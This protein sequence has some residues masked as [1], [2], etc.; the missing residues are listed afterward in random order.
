MFR[1]SLLSLVLSIVLFCNM[2]IAQ[3]VSII[4]KQAESTT[5]SK[6]KANLYLQIV[7]TLTWREKNQDKSIEYANKVIDLCKEECETTRWEAYAYL[8]QIGLGSNDFSI[9]EQQ[10]LP[11]LD[12]NDLPSDKSKALLKEVAGIYFLINGKATDATVA[13]EE[14]RDILKQTNPSSK[15][16][17]N[18]YYYLA[19]SYNANAVNQ[20]SIKAMEQSVEQSRFIKDSLKLIESLSGLS[21]L[22]STDG[23]HL[24]GISF[25]L[26][27]LDISNSIDTDVLGKYALYDVLFDLYIRNGDYQKAKDGLADIIPEFKALDIGRSAKES[28]LWSFNMSMA[29]VQG[30]LGEPE[31]GLVYVDSA[32]VYINPAN[33]FS[34]RITDLRQAGLTLKSGNYDLASIRLEQ[35]LLAMKSYGNIDAFNA[36]LAGQ[37]A[38]L[39]TQSNLKP[40]EGILK[41]LQIIADRVIDKNRGQFNTDVSDAEM[42]S[43]ILDS[44]YQK[45]NAVS[46]HLYNYKMINDTINSREKM[47]V[48]NELLVKY[49]TNE[50]EKE[51]EINQLLLAQKTTERNI[52]I[53]TATALLL[54]IGFLFLFYK[55]KKKYTLQLEKEVKKRTVELEVSNK[56]LK[57]SNEELERYTYIASHDLKEPLRNINSFVGLI[58]RKYLIQNEDAIEYLGFVEKGTKQMTDIVDDL[59]EFSKIRTQDIKIEPIDVVDVFKDAKETVLKEN[60]HK[61]INIDASNLNQKILSDRK[62]IFTVFR[63]IIDNGVKYNKKP[64]IQINVSY[65]KVDDMHQ[66]KIKD[67][68]LGIEADYINTIFTAFKRLHNRS[69]YDGSGAGLAICKRLIEYLKGTI[70]VESEINK[71]TTFTIRLPEQQDISRYSLTND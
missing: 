18:I 26:E 1:V 71:G 12:K 15:R 66:F 47:K 49:E 9:I 58:K 19:F 35:L 42:L 23:N 14:A 8:G 30:R 38:E 27:A 44:Y 36:V 29:K 39:Y 60:S 62:F 4:E 61:K 13:L 57:Q 43:I 10:I 22:Y 69:E 11:K 52:S 56:A 51:L 16:L 53:L 34:L 25:L 21:T 28:T 17:C 2:S 54:G 32:Y 64:E 59:L 70:S 65:D 68:G 41:E 33:E 3:D 7:D 45:P 31:K 5:D 24:K 50:R 37:F 55:E 48:T 20:E 40:S 67:N 63:H 6:M 46:Q